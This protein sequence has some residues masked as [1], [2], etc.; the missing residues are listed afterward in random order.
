MV[1]SLK[2]HFFGP[3]SSSVA[4]TKLLCVAWSVSACLLVTSPAETA[5]PIELPFG[6]WTVGVGG[7]K[8]SVGARIPPKERAI[9]GGGGI[10]WPVIKYSESPA[11]GRYSRPYSTWQQ[12]SMRPFAHFAVNTAP[13][14]HVYCLE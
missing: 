14:C 8:F 7:T 3:P 2:P 11:C 13:V 1:M 12:A 6:I 5:E 10:S 9:F 4:K